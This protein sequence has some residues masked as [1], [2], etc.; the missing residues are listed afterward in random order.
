MVD[1]GFLLISFFVITTELSKPTTLDLNMPTDGPPMDLG[2]SDA[3][4]VL[5]GKDNTAYYYHGSWDEAV[6]ANNVIQTNL[7]GNNGLRK[8]IVEKQ[9]QLDVSNLKEGRKGL[10][11]LIKPGKDA[12]YGQVVDMLDEALISDVKK[13]A[14]VKQ[15]YKEIQY[16]A[17]RS[18]Q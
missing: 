18:Q 3:L 7:S 17:A 16:L 11:L 12:S 1:L 6:R 10:M 8:V 9:H 15:D 5:L 2:E 4:T 14:V 13:Y